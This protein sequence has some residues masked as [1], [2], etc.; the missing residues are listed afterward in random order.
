MNKYCVYMHKNRKNG[1]IYVG[2]T[3]DIDRRWRSSG[4]EYRSEKNPIGEAI[5]QYGWNS[6][7]HIVLEDN[8]SDVEACEREQYY[9]SLYHSNDPECGY[10]IADGGDAGRLYRRGKHPKGMTGKQHTEEWRKRQ[11]ELMKRLNEEGKCGAVW[12]NGHP[13]GM[14]GKHHSEEFK[15]KLRDIPSGQH[16]SAKKVRIR[17][18]D[19]HIVEYECLKYMVEDIGVN[20]TTLMKIIKSGAPYVISP[21]CRTN[22]DNLKK[23]EGAIVY[24]L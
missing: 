1:M 16:P 10:N 20:K 14:L 23:I 15:Q 9:I 22:L 2:K 8:L 3:N 18:Q 21:Q 11:S 6:F 4:V 19:G 17:Y 12:K 24:Y 7:E 13:R 5:S